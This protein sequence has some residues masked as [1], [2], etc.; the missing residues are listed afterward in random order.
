MSPSSTL[1]IKTNHHFVVVRNPLGVEKHHFLVAE[2]RNFLQCLQNEG[3]DPIGEFQTRILN[4]I[5]K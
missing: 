4:P 3:L 2:V 1:M 5:P